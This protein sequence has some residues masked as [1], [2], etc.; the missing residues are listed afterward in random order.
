MG[1]RLVA[2]GGNDTGAG[3]AGRGET[4]SGDSFEGGGAV[5]ATP[6][7]ARPRA[8]TQPFIGI[9]AEGISAR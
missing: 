6:F 7:I 1:G 5:I 8:S 2:A 4:P 3:S 9:V